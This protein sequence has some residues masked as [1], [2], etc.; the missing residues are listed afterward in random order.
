MTQR[1]TGQVAIVTGGAGLI[2]SAISR[3]LAEE[4]AA[5]VINGRDEAKAKALSEELN[6]EGHRTEVLIAS[7]RDEAE[8]AEMIQN[9]VDRH[10][11]LDIVVNNAGGGYGSYT[12]DL[13]LEKWNDVIELNMTGT[14]LCTRAALPH[15]IERGYG[16]F[17][18]ISSAGY[19]GAIGLAGFAAA[20]AGM[21]A[22]TKSVALENA[23]YGVTANVVAPHLVE[24]EGW[25]TRPREWKEKLLAQVPIKRFGT[26]KEIAGVVA[27]FL[28]EDAAYISGEVLHVMGGMEWLGPTIDIAAGRAR[29]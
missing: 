22:F 24:S 27:F 20:K 23:Q 29:D 14:F 16:R 12:K 6:G 4:G 15:M 19:F 26:P 17:V 1:L 10:R 5:V 2:G 18:N 7:V 9:T 13:P 11:R 25:L 28:S 21:N 8:V 3:R